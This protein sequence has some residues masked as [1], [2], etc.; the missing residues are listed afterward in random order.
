MFL[1]L[2]YFCNS[3]YQGATDKGHKEAM[4]RA[5]IYAISGIVIIGAIL[6]LLL[7]ALLG[8]AIS[9]KLERLV[10]YGEA[11]ALIA[12]GISWLT[13]S[14]AFPIITHPDERHSIL[15]SKSR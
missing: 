4:I 14:R 3:F 7:D 11:A 1:V 9:A 8:N 10:F 12:F 2:A 15:L 13:A 6:L 5:K